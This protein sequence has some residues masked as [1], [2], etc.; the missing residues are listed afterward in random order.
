MYLQDFSGISSKKYAKNLR[1]PAKAQKR[2]NVTNSI[3]FQ[4]IKRV[5]NKEDTCIFIGGHS[6]THLAT[7]VGTEEALD[8]NKSM[9]LMPVILI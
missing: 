1:A 4:A 6:G 3:T 7:E 2:E 9:T 5:N 8:N